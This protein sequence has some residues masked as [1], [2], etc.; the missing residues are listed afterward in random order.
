M[1]LVIMRI[2]RNNLS[3]IRPLTPQRSLLLSTIRE[4]GTH[5]DAKELYRR[6]TRKTLVLA[7]LQFTVVY[8]YLRNKA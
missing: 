1:L 7:L 4:A 3:N 5:L 6:A 8:A 2:N